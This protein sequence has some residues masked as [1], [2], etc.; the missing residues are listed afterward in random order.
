MSIEDVAHDT[1]EKIF[2]LNVNP[3]TGPEVDDLL[4]AADDLGITEQKSQLV[5]LMKSLYDCF[6][7]KDCDMIEINPL[8]TTK[9]GV[10]MAADSKVTIDGN[11]GFRQKDLV[12]MED[13]TQVNA[14][15]AHAANYDLNYIHIG[16][17]IGCLVNGA[18][19]AMSTMDIIAL[20][21]GK[22]ANF[23]DVGGS[24]DGDQ[25]TEAIKILN[26]DDE[27]KAIFVNIFGGIL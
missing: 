2:K 11:A 8:I 5:W 26:S 22:P 23:L 20:Y 25:M 3:F 12:A 19:L 7:A 14:K 24:A 21:G 9:E 18:G 13:T 16:G 6:M 10:V 1:P 17:N 4:K 27:V 15:E